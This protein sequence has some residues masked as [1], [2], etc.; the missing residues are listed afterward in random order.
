[1]SSADESKV[2][3]I[4]PF[5]GKKVEWTVWS[6]K[7]LAKS[8]KKGYKQI[9]QGR[10]LAP[11][12]ETDLSQINDKAVRKRMELVR[13]LNK[14]AHE[15][16]L[17]SIDSS[18][19]TGRS[20]CNIVDK[21]RPAGFEEDGYTP[22]AWQNLNDKYAS[23]DGMTRLDL[24]EELS[25]CK[26]KNVR[27]DLEEWIDELVDIQT[28]LIKAGATMSDR[29]IMEYVLL[30]LPKDY[31]TERKDCEKKLDNKTEPLDMK[32][33]YKELRLRYKRL[34]YK[35]RTDRTDEEETVLYAGGS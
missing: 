27:N 21:A 1:M 14:D 4:I 19:A 33:L 12:E 29:D 7:F 5:N 9:L 26:L 35:P 34:G 31:D 2:L 24:K 11:E 17:L 25:N 3:R 16:L 8:R 6:K 28:Q 20:V 18:T 22:T 15:D 30:R 32:Y 13:E 10:E 23:A